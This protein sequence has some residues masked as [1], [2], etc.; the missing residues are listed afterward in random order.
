[1]RCFYRLRSMEVHTS[2]RKPLWSISPFVMLSLGEHHRPPHPDLCPEDFSRGTHRAVPE[3]L[4][5]QNLHSITNN[6][7]SVGH[8]TPVSD[9]LFL[10]ILNIFFHISCFN[11]YCYHKADQRMFFL[12]HENPRIV[13]G[14]GSVPA[15]LDWLSRMW[16]LSLQ[17]EVSVARKVWPQGS[18]KLIKTFKGP[19]SNGWRI[20]L[21]PTRKVGANERD[22]P[23]KSERG[24]DRMEQRRHELP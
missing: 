1:M 7:C 8:K 4:H 13:Q 19:F 16:G 21:S 12:F 3:F 17:Q 5:F 6:D 15:F 14:H 11:C 10:N 22:S 20:Q 24:E 9:F 23:G 18:L 2:A